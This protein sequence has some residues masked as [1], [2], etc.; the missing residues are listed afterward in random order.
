MHGWSSM[1]SLLSAKVDMTASKSLSGS[2]SSVFSNLQE[3]LELMWETI[4]PN[5][6]EMGFRVSRV[7]PSKV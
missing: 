3:W 5:P 6:C 1:I 7:H 2:K 4:L